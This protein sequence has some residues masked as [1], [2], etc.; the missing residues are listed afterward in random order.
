[1][2]F[3]LAQASG[4]DI[5]W[6]II[7]PEVIVCLAA[8]VVMLVDAF[9]NQAQR[10][11]TGTISLIG[12]IAGGASSVWLWSSWRGPTEAF[13]GMIVLDEQLSW[14]TVVGGVMIMGG[15]GLI[16]ATRAKQLPESAAAL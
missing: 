3:F 7:A 5:N 11:L 9:A 15:I 4:A 14:R 13:G 6:W 2:N 8:V 10:W 16:V 12:I 1:M